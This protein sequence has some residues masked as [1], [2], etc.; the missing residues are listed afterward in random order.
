MYAMGWTGG[1]C[2][3]ARQERSHCKMCIVR[4]I[5]MSENLII[6]LCIGNRSKIKNDKVESCSKLRHIRWQCKGTEWA[7]GNITIHTHI[8]LT[9]FDNKKLHFN[10]KRQFTDTVCIY[11][12]PVSIYVSTQNITE[13]CSY[14]FSAKVFLQ[15][16]CT[17][18]FFIFASESRCTRPCINQP[19][20]AYS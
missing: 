3:D 14:V 12:Y 16:F 6:K 13:R 9:L 1:K 7:V 17:L 5:I 10:E 19:C 15:F 8:P 2:C 4:M 11:I 20:T 18:L